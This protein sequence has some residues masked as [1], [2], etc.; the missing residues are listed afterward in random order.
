[1]QHILFT[2]LD[3][4]TQQV[5]TTVASPAPSSDHISLF[6]LLQKGGWIMYPLYFL[7]VA[8]VYVFIERLLALKHYS[9]TEDSFMHLIRENIL[10]GNI[11]QAHNLARST[12]TPI[13]RIVDKG[14]QRIG[15]PIDVIERALESAGQ[16]EVYQMERNL[17]VLS[18]IAAIAP[19]FGFLGTIVGMIELFYA[20][21][22]S[23]F[24]LT[25]IAGGIYVKMIT[26]ASGLIVGVLAYL[27]HSVLTT[28]VNKITNKMEVASSDFIDILHEPTK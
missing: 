12:N 26:S 24:E 13:A 3:L 2:L 23:G 27:G 1:M 16:L 14:I 10:S 4:H 8:A 21:N 9:Q 5:A 28:Q 22:N 20:V 25:T 15:K 6:S 19:M 17:T 11:T 7:F 18:V